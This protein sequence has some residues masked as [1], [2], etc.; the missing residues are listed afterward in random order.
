[1]VSM[2]LKRFGS[3]AHPYYRIV[4]VDKRQARESDTIDEVGQF[5]PC[6]KENQVVL[7]KDKIQEWMKKGVVPSDTVKRILNKNG[8]QIIR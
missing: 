1:M 8:I 3:K 7:D 2:R 6:E 5:R 4:V